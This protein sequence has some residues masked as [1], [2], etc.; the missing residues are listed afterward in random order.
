MT[1]PRKRIGEFTTSGA[2]DGYWRTAV[3]EVAPQ[4]LR[5]RG[6]RAEEIIAK[7]SYAET[8]FMTLRGELPTAAQARTFDAALCAAPDHGLISVHASAARF[9]ASAQPATPVPAIA[10]G[11]L[12][13]GDVTISPQGS[14]T[15]IERGRGL[16]AE[17][18]SREAAAALLVDE[19][20]ELRLPVPGIGHPNHKELDPRAAALRAVAEAEGVWADGGAFYDAVHA[21]FVARKGVRRPMNVDGVL[22]SVLHDLGFTARQTPGIAMIAILPGLLAH[23]DEEITE[24]VPMRVIAESRYTGPPAR[25]LDAGR[26]TP[27]S[28]G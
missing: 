10:A 25:T 21:A 6:Y 17:G 19:H 16:M 27:T 18:A 4:V 13:C 3:S 23:V 2:W 15:L 22:A 24:G 1:E 9:V 5:I 11:L 12:C 20:L 14:A 28:A 7:L 8:L 26:Y